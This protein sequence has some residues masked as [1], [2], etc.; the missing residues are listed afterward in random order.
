MFSIS[1]KPKAKPSTGATVA[2]QPARGFGKVG[3][4]EPQDAAAT[5]S[6]SSRTEVNKRL[7]AM[8]TGNSKAQKRR[9]KEAQNVDETVYQYDEVYDKMQDAKAKA[10]AVK[11]VE[12]QKREPKYIKGLLDSAE[13]RR[14]DYLRAEEKLIA[15]EREAEGAE[16]E[17]KEEFVT[18][19]YKDQMVAL[20]KA[21]AE[22]RAREG[23]QST[24]SIGV[25]KLTCY[26]EE[27][28][29]KASASTGMTHFYAQL[30]RDSE[31]Q[32]SATMS[33]MEESERRSTIGPAA[34]PPNLTIIKP[35][36]MGPK[37][38]KDLVKEAALAGKEVELNDDN[39]IV[40]RRE[41]LSAGLN[42]SAPN[43]RKLGLQTSRKKELDASEAKVHT[44]VGTAATRREINA[45]RAREVNEQLA[46][47]SRRIIEEK[48]REA[49][50]ERERMIT[51][52]ST[53]E[54]VQNARER[55]LARKRRKLEEEGNGE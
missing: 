7:T 38:D 8:N 34:P 37:S 33:A 26:S 30:L 41:L 18:Q 31:Q 13:T 42:L 50:E 29:K 23:D 25:T 4:D 46:E 45:R 1:L 12:S 28:R 20:R 32:H 48:K 22:E 54:D 35:P 49:E 47:E 43:T 5:S 53:E 6:T 40:D 10:K 2:L 9:M 39:Q 21:E 36:E 27:R 52:R 3:D 15:R 24:L 16:F 19:A 17:G 51:K 14:L 55:Y 44:A 11:E